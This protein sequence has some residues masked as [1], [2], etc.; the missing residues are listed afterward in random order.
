[1]QSIFSERTVKPD[2]RRIK[3]GISDVQIYKTDKTDFDISKYSKEERK[4]ILG[5]QDII[6]NREDGLYTKSEVIKELNE[7]YS[8]NKLED[9][10]SDNVIKAYIITAFR[11]LDLNWEKRYGYYIKREHFIDLMNKHSIF[12]QSSYESFRNKSEFVNKI[13]CWRNVKKEYGKT[14]WENIREHDLKEIREELYIKAD[15]VIENFKNDPMA[16]SRFINKKLEE[17]FSPYCPFIRAKKP[18]GEKGTIRIPNPKYDKRIFAL[19]SSK[20]ISNV[21]N[22][23]VMT[24][25][26]SRKIRIFKKNNEC[27]GIFSKY[28]KLD[29]LKK[30]IQEEGLNNM[31]QLVNFIKESENE[32]IKLGTPG[33]H[34]ALIK[35]YGNYIFD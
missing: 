28:I 35:E 19:T 6:K 15:M 23:L 25:E 12:T 21:P 10:D 3:S 20:E 7:F 16:T 33:G 34:A 11:L 14:I 27:K 4:I 2:F 9:I 1:M 29:Q 8:K 30:I 32:K 26:N 13:P 31:S 24:Y 22:T 5:M 17:I 18:N